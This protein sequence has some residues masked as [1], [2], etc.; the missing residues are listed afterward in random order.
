MAN[1]Y[2]YQNFPIIQCGTTTLNASG[3]A[4]VTFISA[5][6]SGSIIF[7]CANPNINTGTLVVGI[8][9]YDTTPTGLKIRGFSKD[10]RPGQ[11]GGGA[12]AGAVRWIAVSIA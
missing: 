9:I 11:D 5:F 4:T 2:T 10:G 6:P 8:S 3:D 12:Y 7:A 1:Y